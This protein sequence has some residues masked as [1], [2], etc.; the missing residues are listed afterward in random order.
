MRTVVVS[1][2]IIFLSAVS[3]AREVKVK[4]I[5]SE[6]NIARYLANREVVKYTSGTIVVS[7]G[8]QI[9]PTEIGYGKIIE[10]K[11]LPTGETEFVFC[12][13]IRDKHTFHIAGIVEDLFKNLFYYII[14][15]GMLFSI[16]FSILIS[17]V[18]RKL[19]ARIQYRQGPPILQNL[20]DLLKLLSK[21]VVVPDIAQQWLFIISPII[22]FSCAVLVSSIIWLVIISPSYSFVGDVI[23]VI[24]LMTIIPVMFIL[25]GSA[26][27]NVIAG[28]GVSREIKL[29]LSYELPLITSLLVPM[30][31]S[32]SVKFADITTASVI[33]S[34]SGIVSF[35]VA[36]ICFV[37][38]VG[39]VPFD[40]SEAET[41]LAGGIFIEYSGF[42]LGLI[43][44][45]KQILFSITPLF[46]IILYWFK[47]PWYSFI[48]KYAVVLIIFIILRNTNPRLK[49]VQI[50]KLFWY[51]VFPI[52]LISVVLALIGV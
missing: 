11:L 34:I 43:K 9:L 30:I 50:T 29:L 26:S 42:L 4:V 24:Y 3:F 27:G 44:I 16:V 21:E 48:L 38:K 22:A 46:L 40:V 31:K 8:E 2:F 47:G 45:T 20:Y 37:A 23:V 7:C 12:Y 19:T 15:P 36:I 39:I 10:K 18:D 52:S 14:F 25:G 13:T 17:W 5:A 49:I 28:I 51:L 35:I 32:S 33:S 41:E 1:I 6:E